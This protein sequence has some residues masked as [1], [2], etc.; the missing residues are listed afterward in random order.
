MFNYFKLLN[1]D[2]SLDGSVFSIDMHLECMSNV[3]LQNPIDFSRAVHM[4]AQM[5]RWKMVKVQK[6]PIHSLVQV[7]QNVI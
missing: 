2:L 1:I 4:K 7:Y 5:Y 6:V 3:G